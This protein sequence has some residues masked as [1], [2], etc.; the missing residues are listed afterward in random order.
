MKKIC[1]LILCASQVACTTPARMSA[2]ELSN[3]QY[4]CSKREEQYQFLE[5]QKY[6][7]NE[8]FMTALQMTSILGIV[9]NIF[10]GTA[11]DSRDAMDGK[12]EAM[13]KHKQR[14][15]R[16]QCRSEDYT[17]WQNAQTRQR[18]EAQERALGYRY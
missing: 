10:N 16:E 12:H 15:L 14:I 1:L 11:D 8:R 3:F 9:S 6:T 2:N 5:S 7:E 18:I 4:D 13:I 17:R